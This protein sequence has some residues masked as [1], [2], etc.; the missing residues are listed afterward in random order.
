M[1]AALIATLTRALLTLLTLTLGA[2]DPRDESLPLT[3]V[4]SYFVTDSFAA[5]LSEPR[6]LLLTSEAAFGQ[7]F[8]S[9]PVMGVPKHPPRFDATWVLAVVLPRG[10][11]S[12]RV[13]IERVVRQGER[14]VVHAVSRASAELSHS[15][16][17]YAV[18]AVEKRAGVTQVAF[19]LND[20]RLAELPLPR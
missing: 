1:R 19:R 13:T 18:V 9:K 2:C 7:V 14:L 12:T 5:E 10:T 8:T 4:G 3:P 16:K 17:P 6:G 20:Q 15:T 11:T